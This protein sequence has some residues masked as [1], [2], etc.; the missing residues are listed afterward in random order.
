MYQSYGC[1]P[2]NRIINS[3]ICIKKKPELKPNKCILYHNNAPENKELSVKQ[4]LAQ[5]LI[6][7]MKQPTYSSDLVLND[8]WLFPKIKSGIKG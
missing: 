2:K 3:Y 5:K 6:T 1:A 8:F 4:F 7:D